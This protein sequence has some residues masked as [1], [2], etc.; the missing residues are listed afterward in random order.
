MAAVA[1]ARVPRELLPEGDAEGFERMLE[2]LEEP[3]FRA[4][5]RAFVRE[6]CAAFA[7][8]GNLD[9]SGTGHPLAWTEL[10]SRYRELFDSQLEGFLTSEGVPREA[11]LKL[12]RALSRAG[13]P[14]RSGW[15][16]FL[17]EVTASEDYAAFVGTMREAGAHQLRE[18]EEASRT[19]ELQT[20]SA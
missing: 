18:T 13:T 3:H 14:W 17:A 1:A 10:H 9:V 5:V 15:E 4:S 16:A 11:F 19:V 8:A 2:A 20:L 7:E 12:A 6:H